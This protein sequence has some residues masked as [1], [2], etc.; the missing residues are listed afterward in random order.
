VKIKIYNE[1]SEEILQR[2]KTL[3][4]NGHS[5]VF[6]KCNWVQ[7]WYETIGEPIHKIQLFIV[8]ITYVSKV[9]VW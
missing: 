8:S 1:F 7:N 4:I 3:E 5:N 2:W 6:Q 9:E